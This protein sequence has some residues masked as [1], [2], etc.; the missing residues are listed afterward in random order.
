M[1]LIGKTAL[2]RGLPMDLYAF[3]VGVPNYTPIGSQLNATF[4]S[5]VAGER[6]DREQ[7]SLKCL[8][9][10]DIGLGRSRPHRDANAGT[11]NV[12]A[13]CELALLDEIIAG[14]RCEDRHI[15]RL[16]AVDA[17]NNE[18][19]WEMNERYLVR[20]LA[21][22]PG[23]EIDDRGAHRRRAHDLDL[24]GHSGVP[25]DGEPAAIANARA[26]NRMR[27]AILYRMSAPGQNKELYRRKLAL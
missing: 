25:Q 18:A 24:G 26:P 5:L 12:D 8:G 1:L 16:A 2:A 3:P 4:G 15:H 20:R 7:R 21:F 9:R 22:E 14:A 17:I 6:L 27:M 11:R 10:G 13:T 23:G 19:R